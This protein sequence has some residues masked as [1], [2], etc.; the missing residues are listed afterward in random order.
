MKVVF[1]SLLW[2]AVAVIPVEGLATCCQAP[3]DTIV[4]TGNIDDPACFSYRDLAFFYWCE[5]HDCKQFL[6]PGHPNADFC[7]V[8]RSNG[9]PFS[10]EEVAAKCR[11]PTAYYE[12][13]DMELFTSDSDYFY[14]KGGE[15]PF[16]TLDQICTDN[17][18]NLPGYICSDGDYGFAG[19]TLRLI[20]VSSIQL[21]FVPHLCQL[22]SSLGEPHFKVK[23]RQPLFGL[24]HAAIEDLLLNYLSWSS[25]W[26]DLGRKMV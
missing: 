24:T 4:E 23:Y 15:G 2:L 3:C 5:I 16:L 12:C 21:G 17:P 13:R 7:C 25:Q 9:Q 10:A 19:G 11:N 14:A 6:E 20:Y 22:S 8:G 1:I 18:L 26:L